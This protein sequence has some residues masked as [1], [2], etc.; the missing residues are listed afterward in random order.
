MPALTP[1]HRRLNKPRL[2][3]LLD[4]LETAAGPATTVCVASGSSEQQI[5]DTLRSA[6]G[7][8]NL[9]PGLG[10]AA[11]RS[12]TGAVVFWG[13][14][15]MYL[16]L[17]PFPV[18]EQ[19]AS[20]GHIVAPVRSLLQQ[21]LT[22]ALIVVRLGAYA[23]GV[24]RDDVLVSSKVGTG[25]VHSRHRQ[26]GSSQHRFE[27]HRD[28]Q[29]EYFFTRICAHAREHL[30]PHIKKLDY[31]IYGGERHTLLALREQCRFLAQFD[32]RTL[33][34][35]LNIREPR[36]V[37]LQAAIGDVWSSEVTQWREGS[38]E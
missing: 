8:A 31:L 9:P 18:T 26:G 14:E 13:Q 11:A 21:H 23:I 5:E 34:R 38:A 25:L 19:G 30:E 7:P 1:T 37:S 33:P 2:L 35:L 20:I 29:I 16:V 10:Q 4:E 22:I 15:H 36:Q 27:R 12:T 28:K 24:F 3:R 6:L 32:D 17:P